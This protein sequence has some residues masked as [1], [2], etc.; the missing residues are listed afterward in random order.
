[1]AKRKYGSPKYAGKTAFKKP[2][3]AVGRP[4]PMGT[5][6][7][8]RGFKGGYG[9]TANELKFQDIGVT[10]YQVNT[11]ASITLL[12][13][14]TLG[15]DFNNRI[16]RKTLI[17][18]LFIRGRL[19]WEAGSLNTNSQHA[20]MIVLWDTQPN[21]AAPAATDVLVSAETASQLNPNNRDRFKVLC[22]KQFVMGPFNGATP[23]FGVPAGHSIKLYKKLSLETI[24]NS[25]NGGTIGDINSGALYMFWIGT[26][27]SG[28]NDLNAI[29]STRVRYVD[30]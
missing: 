28:T 10:T 14:P 8:T 27:A 2:R 29:L 18:S 9:K 1:M 19:F 7:A 6:L 22:D 25:T 12:H 30:S 15:S 24:F 20:R 4:M 17:K 21:G 3:L 5:A 16:G 11:T 23:A 26:V 13:I